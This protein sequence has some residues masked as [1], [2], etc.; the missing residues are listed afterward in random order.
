MGLHT[1]RNERELMIV[2]V[3]GV[4][5]I[6]ESACAIT[7]DGRYRGLVHVQGTRTLHCLIAQGRAPAEVLGV[8]D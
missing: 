1:K 2:K 3:A 8:G 7:I 4:L 5:R 6:R